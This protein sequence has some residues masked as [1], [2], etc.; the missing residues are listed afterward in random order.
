MVR[1]ALPLVLILLA[2]GCARSENAADVHVDENDSARRVERV[3]TPAQ[4]DEEPAI[5]Q[6]RDSLQDEQRSLEFGPAGTPPLFSLRCDRRHGMLLQRHGAVST[7][8]LP[9][10]LISIGSETRRLAVTGSGGII[11]MLRATLPPGDPLLDKLA[12]HASPI[13]IRIG[14]SPPL[15]LPPSPAIGEYVTE[16]ASGNRA[17][18]EATTRGNDAAATGTNA[19]GEPA[20]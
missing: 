9:M 8:D 10:M 7:G 20:R 6:W 13:V 16:C 5:G 12:Q 19:A 1:A 4:D 11:P 18:P 17:A 14:D 15:V 2:A 3:H